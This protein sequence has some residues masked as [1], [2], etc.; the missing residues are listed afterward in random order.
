MKRTP[1]YKA[2]VLSFYSRSFYR[3]V[4]G[5]WRW[6]SAAYLTLL[7][8]VCWLPLVFGVAREMHLEAKGFLRQLPEITLSNGRVTVDVEQP[9]FIYSLDGEEAVIIDTTGEITSL[10][11]RVAEVLLTDTQLIARRRAYDTRTVDLSHAP[12]EEFRLTSNKATTWYRIFGV[13]MVPF[14]WGFLVA[15]SLVYRVL[16]A[17]LYALFGLVIARVAKASLRYPSILC[18]AMVAITPSLILKTLLIHLDIRFSFSWLLFFAVAMGFLGF[19]IVS[20][21]RGEGSTE[22]D[23]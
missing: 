2:V 14:M 16:Q 10:D 11:E 17:L 13:A 12:V 20:T 7:L 3:E 19:A 1:F 9:Y 18:L 6:R 4:A 15:G 23:A 21:A 8:V 22:A 5:L